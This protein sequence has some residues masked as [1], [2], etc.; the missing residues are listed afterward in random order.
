MLQRSPHS[1]VS[2]FVVV[3]NILFLWSLP[4]TQA[5]QTNENQTDRKELRCP[6]NCEPNGKCILNDS[7]G[8]PV[9]CECNIG[10]AGA[11]CSFPYEQCPDGFTTCYDGAK[12]SRG[13]SDKDAGDEDGRGDQTYTCD[14]EAMVGVS[15]FV[16][17]QCENPLDDV[18]EMG[19]QLSEYAFCTN[20][21]TCLK[22]IDSGEAHPGCD[23]PEEFEGRHCQY[24][25]G[26]AP[27]AELML[28]WN[29]DPDE[30]GEDPMDEIAEEP[31][32]ILIWIVA[33][34]V[35]ILAAL[36]IF[37]CCVYARLKNVSEKRHEKSITRIGVI[38]IRDAST[39]S[40]DEEKFDDIILGG[41]YSDDE[42][43]HHKHII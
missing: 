12:C 19:V 32:K 6:G 17:Q 35:S 2:V 26:T 7:D 15:D 27:P 16:I 5:Q 14:C 29:A 39:D 30:E 21:G 22:L 11:D 40:K 36:G 43:D 9:R 13:L 20:S 24:A 10:F 18:C 34:S 38:S 23:C 28:V 42:S 3:T 37:A 31:T 8:S 25:A 41:G 1:L 33:A 4:I